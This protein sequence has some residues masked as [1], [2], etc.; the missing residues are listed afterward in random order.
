MV[1]AMAAALLLALPAYLGEASVPNI[2]IS[3][4]SVLV[5]GLP[6]IATGQQRS[7]LPC[8]LAEGRGGGRG[9]IHAQTRNT[10][11]PSHVSRPYPR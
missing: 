5:D 6:F 11:S 1:K 9:R 3:G 10:L 8:G 7:P 2:T 4:R